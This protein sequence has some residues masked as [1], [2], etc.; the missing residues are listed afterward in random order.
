[1]DVVR[2]YYDKEAGYEWERLNN[3]Y[4]RVEMESTLHLIDKY[5]PKEGRILDIGAGPGRYSMALLKKGY[6][7][8]LLDISKVELQLAKEM[9]TKEGLE[10]EAYYCRSALDLSH[11]PD[12]SFDGVMIMGPLYH[13]HEREARD[14]VLK[15]AIRILKPGAPALI[16]YINSWGCL[17]AAVYEF[18]DVFADKAHF[19][20]Y[21][22]GDLKFS[23]EESFTATFFTT[24]VK[25]LEEV[26]ASGLE[27]IS[28][29]AAEGFLSALYPQLIN[30]SKEKPEIYENF[31]RA[32]VL[33]CEEPQ[34][35]DASEHLH[36]IA[37]KSLI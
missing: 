36:I 19:Q 12:S 1:M 31:V 30:L 4:T 10:A 21:I 37:K 2:D 33:Y 35:R 8:S 9:I 25:A 15:E 23:A 29:A 34:Y 22:A 7:V 28:Y 11:L 16:A 20:R 6:R 17:K 5:F 24:P 27:I 13:L 14:T 18:P 26:K 3:A 32:S